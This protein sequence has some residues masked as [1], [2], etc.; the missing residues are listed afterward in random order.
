[1][2]H[3]DLQHFHKF[4]GLGHELMVLYYDAKAHKY[5]VRMFDWQQNDWVP[6]QSLG[7]Q[8]LFLSRRS[9]YVDAVNYYGVS[10]NKIYVRRD[11]NCYV[12]SLKNG[13]L[14]KCT[15]SGLRNWDGLD[16]DM[17]NSVWVDPRVFLPN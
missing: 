1:M 3:R 17:K 10:A 7:N 15:L 8:S 12:Y 4:F 2:Y 5:C 6:L 14:L 16:Y 9:V 13:R 11:R